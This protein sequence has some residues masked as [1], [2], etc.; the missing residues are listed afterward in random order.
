MG[1]P[2]RAGKMWS[3][4]LEPAKPHLTNCRH[5]VRSEGCTKSTPFSY[6]CFRFVRSCCRYH[7][8]LSEL[9]LFWRTTTSLLS[10]NRVLKFQ[11]INLQTSSRRNEAQRWHASPFKALPHLWPITVY[12]SPCHLLRWSE[13]CLRADV[14]EQ[15]SAMWRV[16][17]RAHVRHAMQSR[18]NTSECV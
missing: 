12:L 2:T 9:R 3:G 4:K 16:P 13:Q 11:L 1:R 6:T 17:A 8:E 15:I 7:T 5:Y 10:P 14:F 18:K